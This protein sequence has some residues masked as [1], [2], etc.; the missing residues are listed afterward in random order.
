[1]SDFGRL[2]N[3]AFVGTDR[4]SCVFLPQILM[5]GLLCGSHPSGC[6]E[7]GEASRRV[8]PHRAHIS[9]WATDRNRKKHKEP[10]AGDKRWEENRARQ[11][12]LEAGRSWGDGWSRKALCVYLPDDV[13]TSSVKVGKGRFKKRGEQVERPPAVQ[14]L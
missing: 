6:C 12:G 11:D 14:T 1:M 10:V 13:T 8:C 2:Y 7:F 3:L 4:S 9:V 5:E